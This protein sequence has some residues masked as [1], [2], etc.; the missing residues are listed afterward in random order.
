[1]CSD[2]KST[3]RQSSH[4]CHFTHL[5]SSNVK[6]AC[7]LLVKLTQGV[8]FINI[9]TQSFFSSRSQNRK[10][11]SGHQCHFALLRSSNVK[12][13]CKNVGEINPEFPI[14]VEQDLNTWLERKESDWSRQD[15]FVLQPKLKLKLRCWI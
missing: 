9:S 4:Q 8:N 11:K 2:P 15:Q 7:K 5:G 1:M 10:R 14:W 6:T 12:A 13:A 3:N